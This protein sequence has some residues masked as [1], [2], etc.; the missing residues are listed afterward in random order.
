MRGKYALLGATVL[1]A[2]S[3]AVYSKDASATICPEVSIGAAGS[4][5]TNNPMISSF[6]E[7]NPVTMIYNLVDNSISLLQ[8][9]STVGGPISNVIESSPATAIYNLI[10]NT[11][12]L[13]INDTAGTPINIFI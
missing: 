13:Q 8:T 12:T 2:L 4:C 1:A 5:T 10:E 11:I 9:I 6:I 7:N 3:I